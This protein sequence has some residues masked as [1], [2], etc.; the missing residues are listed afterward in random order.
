MQE[1]AIHLGLVITYG[2]G[3][4]GGYL[5]GAV[6]ICYGFA[7]LTHLTSVLGS[8]TSL[9][10]KGYSPEVTMLSIHAWELQRRSLYST[11]IK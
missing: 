3:E 1:A 11:N 7:N 8:S 6:T 9:R 2:M 10:Y 4:Q 5:T